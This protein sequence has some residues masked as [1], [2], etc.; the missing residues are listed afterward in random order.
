MNTPIL[1][2]SDCEGAGAMFQATT[3]LPEKSVDL[4]KL[5]R[6]KDAELKEYIDYTKD[7]FKKPTFLTVSG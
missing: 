1:T 3:I 4:K 6:Y 5:S 7:F 2:S